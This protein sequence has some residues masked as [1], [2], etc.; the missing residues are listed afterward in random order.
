MKIKAGAIL[1]GLN[2]KMRL[3][4]ICANN[5]WSEE[6]EELW[7]TG[8]LDG[9]HS[10]GS[11]HYYGF[12]LD[13]RSRDFTEKQKLRVIEKLRYALGKDYDVVSH[14]THIHVE[15]DPGK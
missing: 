14:T 4:L 2:I 11:L 8:G 3:V 6:G 13:L 9:T 15:Y 7:I 10:A 5:I 12:A 1:A